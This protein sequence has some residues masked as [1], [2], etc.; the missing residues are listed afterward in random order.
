MPGIWDDVIDPM[1]RKYTGADFPFRP[2]TT[3]VY[4]VEVENAK[5][6]ELPFRAR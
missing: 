4:L 1:A 3:V 6:R 5:L 2:E